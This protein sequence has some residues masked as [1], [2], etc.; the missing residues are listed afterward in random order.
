MEMKSNK[1]KWARTD[2]NSDWDADLSVE[3]LQVW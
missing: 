2:K 1:N 3:E